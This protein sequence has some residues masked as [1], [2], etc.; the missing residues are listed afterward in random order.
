MKKQL[1]FAK[2]VLLLCIVNIISTTLHAQIISTFA[3]S[4]LSGGDSGDGGPATSALVGIPTGIA[5]DNVGNIYFSTFYHHHIKKV[6]TSGIIT[7]IAGNDSAG[8][9]GD[10][11]PA[12]NA[13]LYNPWGIAID[14]FGNIFIADY[15]NSCVRRI[16]P[17]GI[18][19]TF[20]GNPSNYGYGGDGGDATAAK[21]SKPT[22]VAADRF[23]NVY[24][25]DYYNNVVRKV[26]GGIIT[27][28]AGTGAGGHSG[29]GGPA[30]AA[31]IR[32]PLSVAVDTIGN[33]YIGDSLSFVRKVNASGIISTIA[34]YGPYGYSGD[35]GPATA[36]RFFVIAAITTD[37]VG[38]VFLSDQGNHVIRTVNTSGI[39][40]TYAGTGIEGYNG[41][42][43]L[44]VNAQLNHPWGIVMDHIGCL[45]IAD[46]GNNLVRKVSAPT[47]VHEVGN[48]QDIS[49]LPN[50]ATDI[51]RIQGVSKVSVK[52]Y[53]TMGRLVQETNN[54]D[55]ISVSAFPAGI[56]FIR[57]FSTNNELLYQGKLIKE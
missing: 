12:I 14:S 49:V 10:G 31:Q 19:T 47:S 52:V 11:G 27:T 43:I 57:L 2:I 1:F 34:G 23:G 9:S 46:D 41:D 55:I 53:N 32:K 30:T 25:S 38:D 16:D 33:V 3:G 29:D 18:I 42:G 20:A 5:I 17:S 51:V 56:Y 45:Y 28:F 6:S 39:V 44:A 21:M 50:P 37:K 48:K 24:I 13:R 22:G 15:T 8:Y 54:T 35:G 40:S 7:T 4:S 26:T 36:A